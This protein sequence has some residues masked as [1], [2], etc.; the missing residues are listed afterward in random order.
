M[1][2]WHMLLLI[3]EIPFYLANKKQ[4]SKINKYKISLLKMSMKHDGIQRVKFETDMK[5][6]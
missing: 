6:I 2:Q 4:P 3:L 1:L 5:K